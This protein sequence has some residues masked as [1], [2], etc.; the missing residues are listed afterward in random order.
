MSEIKGIDQIFPKKTDEGSGS[1]RLWAAAGVIALVAAGYAFVPSANG[2]TGPT[3][4]GANV[5]ATVSAPALPAAEAKP[6][7][8][9]RKPAPPKPTAGVEDIKAARKQEAKRQQQE[10]KAEISQNVQAEA[11]ATVKPG[12]RTCDCE[13]AEL[14]LPAQCPDLSCRQCKASCGIPGN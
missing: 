6:V 1:F 7:V 2:P 9:V 14:T 4:S 8:E 10:Q 12:G 13:T 3:G 11:K 5:S